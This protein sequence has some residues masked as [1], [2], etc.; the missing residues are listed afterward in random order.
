MGWEW[1]TT[2]T[3]IEDGESECEIQSTYE[4]WG[5][6]T[7]KIEDL[8]LDRQIKARSKDAPSR[9]SRAADIACGPGICRID[10]RSEALKCASCNS[11]VR[12][13]RQARRG[14]N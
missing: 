12:G 3:T 10:G 2:A 5:N 11:F 7:G 4:I 14:Q 13:L 8:A 1:P 6:T 9:T